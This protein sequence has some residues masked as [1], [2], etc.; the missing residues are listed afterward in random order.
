MTLGYSPA[1]EHR[2]TSHKYPDQPQP[3]VCGPSASLPES[4]YI[5][6]TRLS[7]SLIVVRNAQR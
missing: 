3:E 5:S 2:T 4:I 1:I 6:T 7:A